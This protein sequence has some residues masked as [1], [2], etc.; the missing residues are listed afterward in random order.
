MAFLV[1]PLRCD[2]SDVIYL[3]STFGIVHLTS[4]DPLPSGTVPESVVQFVLTV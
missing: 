4:C 1:I 2:S 3:I